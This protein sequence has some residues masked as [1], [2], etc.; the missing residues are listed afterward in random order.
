[1]GP[2]NIQEGPSVNNTLS[3][4]EEQDTL[5]KLLLFLQDIRT[6]A[7][8]LVFLDVEPIRCGHGTLELVPAAIGVLSVSGNSYL[9]PVECACG[10]C[11]WNFGVCFV[12][13]QE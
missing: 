5:L 3:S 11:E 4:E 9:R 7:K 6:G 8:V 12:C 10:F 1:M 13:G 2:T